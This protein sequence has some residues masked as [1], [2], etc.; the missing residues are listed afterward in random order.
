MLNSVKNKPLNTVFMFI[1]LL[2]MQVTCLAEVYKYKDEQ[3][4]WQFSDK[5]LKGSGVKRVGGTIS[6]T[7][8]SAGL[9]DV[10][11]QLNARYQPENPVQRATLSVVTV[12]SKL[13]NGSGF[14]VTDNCYLITNRHVVR[15]AKGKSWND[16]QRKIKKSA[17]EFE[18]TRLKIQNERQRLAISKR[19]LDDF[20]HYLDNLSSTKERQI[21]QQEYAVYVDR[22]QHD[23]QY[24]DDFSSRFN[25][26]ERAFNKQRSNFEFSSSIASVAKSFELTL[27]DNSKLRAKLIKVSTTDDLALLKVNNCHSP[28]LTLSTKRL[29]QGLT[30]HAIGSPLGLRDQLTRGTVTQVLTNGVV[31]DAQILPGNSGGPLVNDEGHVVAVNTLKIAKGSALNKGFGVSI[32]VL[33]LRQNFS[34]LFD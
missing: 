2:L 26:G 7:F 17:A 33:R 29:S 3:G 13:G 23:K 4:R 12:N 21:A 9:V 34:T 11:K 14:F 19:K 1:F 24:I 15:P 6:S 22:Y 32:P 30:V 5:P 10:A 27:K 18:H 28:F 31:T 25:E 16:T 8:S 20:K